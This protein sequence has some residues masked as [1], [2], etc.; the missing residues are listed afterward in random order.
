MYVLVSDQSGARIFK[1]SA[2]GP[3]VSFSQ[4]EAQLDRASNLH[5]LY[6]SG[7]QSFIYSV[8][9]PDGNITQQEIYDYLG[10]RPRLGVNDAG[11]IV[12]QGGVR[13]VK[14]G[15]LPVVKAPDELPLRARA[16][17]ALR[18]AACA[19]ISD[20]SLG[21]LQQFSSGHGVVLVCRKDVTLSL[22]VINNHQRLVVAHKRVSLQKGG[23]HLKACV[24]ANQIFH[25]VGDISEICIFP[26]DSRNDLQLT[27]VLGFALGLALGT[28]G[29]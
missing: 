25:P 22:D 14:P 4:P 21:G 24:Q 29:E 15:E 2:I 5:V 18:T 19:C 9:N 17:E 7:A 27:I 26:I 20:S 28:A 23:L 8:V 12:V 11:D 6:Q 16:G 1:V 3:M 10:T 13:R